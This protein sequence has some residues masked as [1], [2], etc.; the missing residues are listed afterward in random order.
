VILS[1]GKSVDNIG[2]ALRDCFMPKESSALSP[3]KQVSKARQ[4]AEEDA[5]ACLIDDEQHAMLSLIF[6]SDPKSADAYI[7]E[8]TAAGH[9]TLTKILISRF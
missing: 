4:I 5:D 2:N 1:L 6:G 3:T 9:Q 8:R 7:A